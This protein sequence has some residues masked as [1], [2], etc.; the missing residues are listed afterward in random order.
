[1]IEVQ[2]FGC[3]EFKNVTFKY[4][5]AEEYILRNISFKINEGETLTF[6]GSTGS[7]KPTIINL[8]MRFVEN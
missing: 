4:L 7:G 6:I 2:E 3:I 5:D 1:M 8:L